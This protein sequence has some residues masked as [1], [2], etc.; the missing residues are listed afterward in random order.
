MKPA[1][2]DAASAPSESFDLEKFL[3]SLLN[4]QPVEPSLEETGV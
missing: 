1:A 3:Q 2:S 4:E